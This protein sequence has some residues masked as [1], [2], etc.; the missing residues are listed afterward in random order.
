LIDLGRAPLSVRRER[1]HVDRAGEGASLLYASD[2]HLGRD[3]HARAAELA[4]LCARHRPDAVLLGGDLVDAPRGHE[5]LA[6]LVEDLARVAPVLAVPGNHDHFWG[7]SRVEEAVEAG[8]GVWVERAVVRIPTRGGA[9]AIAGRAQALAVADGCARVLCGH[10]PA[11]LDEPATLAADLVLAGHLHGG[12]VVLAERAERLF[13]GALFYRYCGLRFVR[14][15]T[16]ML[17]SRGAH[18]TIPLRF[19]CPREVLLV[20]LRDELGAGG[21]AVTAR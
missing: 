20:E 3:D 15:A 14:G 6:A 7:V 1:L 13:P 2:L 10:D 18:D 8:G 4:E 12:Q 17:V 5:L 19:R 16:T 21:S 9:I 11:V